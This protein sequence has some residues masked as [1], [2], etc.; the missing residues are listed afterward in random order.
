MFWSD[1]V[2]HA[3]RILSLKEDAIMALKIDV[4]VLKVLQEMRSL[5]N[6]YHNDEHVS[7]VMV[8]S[9]Q[10]GTHVIPELSDQEHE[11]LMVAA[12]FHDAGHC[13][14]TD[15]KT[16]TRDVPRKDLTNEEYS[17]VLMREALQNHLPESR[18][19]RIEG[20]ILSTTFGQT[21]HPHPATTKLE[22]ILVL[23]DVGGFLKPFDEWVR[24]SLLVLE[25]A[26]P[27]GV[28]ADFAAWKKTR[29]GFLDGYVRGLLTQILPLVDADYGTGLKAKLDET[30]ALVHSD[31]DRFQPDFERVCSARLANA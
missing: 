26:I 15:R 19:A 8:R 7:Q 30:V 14:Q 25:E 9:D 10:I 27:S 18:L 11:D 3:F 24:E 5:D 2:C 20:M 17:V 12:L 22:K 16:C 6:E 23:A 21:P 13:G 4:L 1:G 28:P 31:L 29:I